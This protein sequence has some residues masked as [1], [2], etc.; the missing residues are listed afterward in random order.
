[1]GCLCIRARTTLHYCAVCELNLQCLYTNYSGR[2]SQLFFPLH[3]RLSLNV[4]TDL[5]VMWL[6]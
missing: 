6:P 5:H 2:Q 4:H 1:M 3:V